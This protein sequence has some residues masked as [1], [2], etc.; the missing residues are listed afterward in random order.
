[1]IETSAIKIGSSA[2]VLGDKVR[3]DGGHKRSAFVVNQLSNH[4]KLIPFCPE[5]GIGMPV[6]RPAIQLREI[7]DKIELVDSKT[8]SNNYTQAMNGYFQT[9]Q[10]KLSQLDGY[11]L[12]AKSPSC[13][14][15]RIKVHDANG[16]Q[17]H[18]DGAGIFAKQLI[19]HF[20]SLPVEEDGRL[21]DK[22]IRESFFARVHAHATFRE[23]V[24]ADPKPASLVE[25]HTRYKYLVLAYNPKIYYELG[26]LVAQCGAGDFETVAKVYLHR[27]MTA[28]SKPTNRKKHT[29]VL[30]HLQ[31]FFKKDLDPE[32]KQELAQSIEHF[33]QGYIPL[34]AP[35]TLINHYL[36]QFP[37]TFLKKQVYLA[38]F[39]LELGIHA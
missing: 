31:G 26:P 7:D 27:L 10:S 25:F 2:C 8:G 16:K 29:N 13:G 11:I 9:N 17:L 24:A 38:P 19:E 28:L 22:G 36:M 35:L 33:Y 4:Y 21:N 12:A 5:V 18:R 30:M 15:E 3:Y 14:M 34:L 32:C 39:P 1:M 6:P 20:P 23:M 37:N